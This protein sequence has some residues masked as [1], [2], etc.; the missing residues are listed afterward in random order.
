[1]IVSLSD[2]DAHLGSFRRRLEK[3]RVVRRA[4]EEESLRNFFGD[5]LRNLEDSDEEIIVVGGPKIIIDEFRRFVEEKGTKKRISY[6]VSP[7]TG[8]KGLKDIISKRAGSII[9]DE[10]RK[11]V[12]ELIEEFLMHLSKGDGLASLEREDV[13]SGN[14]KVLLVH[15]DAVRELRDLMKRA[16]EMGANVFIVLKD[17]DNEAVVRKLGGALIIRR[18]SP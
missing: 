1:L 12:E 11:R 10:R 17:Y 6:V 8:E 5:V 2:E 4:D 14:V 7:I 9:K 16:K 3:E 15:Q 18:Y 13:E